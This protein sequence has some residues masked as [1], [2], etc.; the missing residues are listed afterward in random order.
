VGGGP[1]GASPESAGALD[2]QRDR[3]NRPEEHPASR[4][5]CLRTLIAI[6]LVLAGLA[7]TWYLFGVLVDVLA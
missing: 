4:P 5:G 7:L 6:V 1:P 3:D 2:G